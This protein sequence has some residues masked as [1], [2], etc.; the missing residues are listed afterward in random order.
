[1]KKE[2]LLKDYKLV[3]ETTESN[4]MKQ[5]QDVRVKIYQKNETQIQ[6]IEETKQYRVS[7]NFENYSELRKFED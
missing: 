6:V 2:D 4:L 7:K 5:G 3:K 1:M